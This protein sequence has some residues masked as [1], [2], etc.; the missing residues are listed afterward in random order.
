MG[1]RSV[2]SD[3]YRPHGLQPT[4]LLHP[5]DFPGKSTGV[6]C[7]CL[8]Q[9][10]VAVGLCVSFVHVSPSCAC[11]HLLLVPYSFFVFRCLR[12]SMSRWKPC[13]KWPQKPVCLRQT[14]HLGGRELVMQ[15]GKEESRLPLLLPW[16]NLEKLRLV[17]GVLPK[18]FS[19]STL[20]SH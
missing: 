1:S 9:L 13:S 6:A 16:A 4:R 12:R 17:Y 10:E 11:T 5:W 18:L 20:F 19:W 2:M 15:S 8:L 7:R 3:L 14:L